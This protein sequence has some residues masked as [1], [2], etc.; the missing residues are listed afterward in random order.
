MKNDINKNKL[1]TNIKGSHKMIQVD[2]KNTVS[3]DSI[4]MTS[5]FS[6]SWG[7]VGGWSGQIFLPLR[8]DNI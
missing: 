5:V 6:T 3:S 8:S 1:T 2:L 4:D 7:S